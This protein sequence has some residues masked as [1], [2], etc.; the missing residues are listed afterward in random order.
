LCK[1]PIKDE[2]GEK[3]K[4][5]LYV[6]AAILVLSVLS[7][8]ALSACAVSGS[9]SIEV[10]CDEFMEQQ[11]VTQE[12]EV[13]VGESL[14]VTLCSNPTTGFQ[15]QAAEIGDATVLKETGRRPVAAGGGQEPR[16]GAAGH[17]EWTF[18]ALKA[19]TTTVSIAYSRPWEGGEK[20]T[21]TYD[22]TVT[23][24]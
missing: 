11:K 4:S 15:W 16:V 2:G 6:S 21:W 23:V 17:E 10:S 13:P 19:G 24:K 7:V 3:V 20:G 22:L 5:R 14:I 8:L 18:E 12:V 1:P 9:S